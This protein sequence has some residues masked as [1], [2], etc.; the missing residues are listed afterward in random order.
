M[1]DYYGLCLVDENGVFDARG[2]D[3]SIRLRH[4]ARRLTTSTRPDGQS[5]HRMIVTIDRRVG[6]TYPPALPKWEG[7]LMPDGFIDFPEQ[8]VFPRSTSLSPLGE[9]GEGFCISVCRVM[10]V[11][12]FDAK[13]QLQLRIHF[14]LF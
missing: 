3:A 6:L 8:H 13:K 10:G 11:S 12:L 7:S 14:L 4:S 2:Y 1:D 9:T 5:V